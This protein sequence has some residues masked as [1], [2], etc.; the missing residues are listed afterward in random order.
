ML[1]LEPSFEQPGPQRD[2]PGQVEAIAGGLLERLTFKV[3]RGG[4]CGGLGAI[5]A[6]GAFGA[7][8][9]FQLRADDSGLEYG[10]LADTLG[11]GEHGAQVSMPADQAGQRRLQCRRI[12]GSVQA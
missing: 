3:G 7:V 8:E 9:A 2:L 6:V 1:G 4:H 10:L 11:L 5:G 12:Q